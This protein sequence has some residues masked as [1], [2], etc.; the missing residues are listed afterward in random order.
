MVEGSVVTALIPSFR[1]L[2]I[3]DRSVSGWSGGPQMAP[4]TAN[5]TS[6]VA[7]HHLS[8]TEVAG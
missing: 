5:A 2:F 7:T 8:A 4:K 3:P 6:S 1:A